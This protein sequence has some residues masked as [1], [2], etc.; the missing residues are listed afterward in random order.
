MLAEERRQLLLDH[1]EREGRLVAK[2]VADRFGLSVDSIRR[3]LAILEEQGLLKKT[4][5]GAIPATQVRILPQPEPIRYGEGMPHQNAI[6]K[7]AVSYLNE[8]D[9]VFIGGA[10]IQFGM[11]RY[12]PRTLK[13]TIVTNSL[14]IAQTIREWDN[15]ESYL[16]GGKLSA[17][18]GN[19]TDTL[20]IEQVRRFSFDVGFF[21]GG[22]L[23]ARGISTATPAG[24]SFARA[25]CDVSRK[26]IGL[27]PHEKLGTD[28]FAH[29]F[30]ASRLDTLITDDR[31]P[32]DL[33]D[34]LEAL[35]IEVRIVAPEAP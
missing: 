21:T 31:A 5:G 1:L 15:V 33:L 7:L 9:S 23:T 34:E 4:Y 12:I 32:R 13:L 22:G 30:E 28:M 10:G 17:S 24:A 6:S 29:S 16:I 35:G 18:S 11:L 20:A 3:D 26:R 8:G 2:E 27:I 14:K 25:Q 19:I